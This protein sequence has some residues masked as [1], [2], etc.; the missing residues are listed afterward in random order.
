ML[1]DAGHEI[2]VLVD[3]NTALVS[4]FAGV[5]LIRPAA[6]SD[7]ISRVDAFVVAIGGI[8]PDRGTVARQL[9]RFDLVP[10]TLVHD[11][12]WVADDAV[13]G[14]GVQVC[15]MAAIAVGVT[16]GDFSIVNT[17]TGVDHDCSLGFGGHVMPGATIA[18]EVTVAPGATIGA[19][20]TVLPGVTV[21]EGAVVGAGAVVT[22]DVAPH[23]VVAGVPARPLA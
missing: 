6:V 12:A 17:G 4:P 2:V 16:I 14:H 15:A 7:W 19:N 1:R 21:G 20:A 3:R 9:L 18:G 13:L 10:I 8:G 5:P 23:A 22:R 11:R